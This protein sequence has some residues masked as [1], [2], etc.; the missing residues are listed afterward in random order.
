MEE[1]RRH[2][3]L[4]Q[5]TVNA[6]QALLE[7]QQRRNDDNGSGKE[8]SSSR[9]SRSH[10]RQTRMNDIKV[11]I[12]DFEGK[13]HPHEFVDGLQTVERVF[14]YKVV[15]EEQKVKIVVVKLKKHT[16]IWWESVKRKREREGKSKIKKWEKMCRELTRKFLPPHYYKDNFIQLQ[17][18]RKKSMSVEE[19]TRDFEKLM[20]KCDI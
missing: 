8:S 17:N 6:Q 7:V 13:L 15:P 9:S 2:I 10:R 5:E 20:M 14:E 19:Y 12:P 11:D 4:L 1:M 3:Q 16:P 18:L